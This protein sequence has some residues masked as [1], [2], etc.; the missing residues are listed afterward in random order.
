MQNRHMHHGAWA[1][2]IVAFS[3]LVDIEMDK[4]RA[5]PLLL[6]EGIFDVSNSHST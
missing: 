6:A 5:S 1:A 4:H 2:A 3:T